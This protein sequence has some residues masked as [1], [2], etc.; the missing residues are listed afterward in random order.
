ML[1]DS[2][3]LAHLSLVVHYQPWAARHSI[4]HEAMAGIQYISV[5]VMSAI[6]HGSYFECFIKKNRCKFTNLSRPKCRILSITS[7]S[8]IGSRLGQNTDHYTPLWNRVSDQECMLWLHIR[9]CL[10]C[11]SPWD[12]ANQLWKESSYY[13]FEYLQQIGHLDKVVY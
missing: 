2:S 9:T 7:N 12:A 6:D 3:T 11:S 4:C 5:N 13:L 8:L 1:H 10:W